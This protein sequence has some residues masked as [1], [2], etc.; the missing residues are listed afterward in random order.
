MMWSGYCCDGSG[1]SLPDIISCEYPCAGTCTGVHP[2]LLQNVMVLV[3]L[4]IH[5]LLTNLWTLRS[6]IY[7]GYSQMACMAAI[8]GGFQSESSLSSLELLNWQ[9][10]EFHCY[11]I[12]F[13]WKFSCCMRNCLVLHDVLFPGFTWNSLHLVLLP[14]DQIHCFP[15]RLW[16]IALVA[17]FCLVASSDNWKFLALLA[18]D[19]VLDISILLRHPQCG[20]S[21]RSQLPTPSSLQQPCRLHPRSVWGCGSAERLVESVGWSHPNVQVRSTCLSLAEHSVPPDQAFNS[22]YAVVVVTYSMNHG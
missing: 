18:Q 22:T 9:W 14:V 20:T 21:P 5:E 19:A 2:F 15:Y 4:H 6:Y 12:Y 7:W 11:C 3:C 8:S 10:Q 13:Y 17:A 16:C 1:R